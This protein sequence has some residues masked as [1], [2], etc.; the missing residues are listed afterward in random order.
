MA[1]NAP[2]AT[3]MTAGAD[4]GRRRGR[5]IRTPRGDDPDEEPE[6]T[7]HDQPTTSG[8]TPGLEPVSDRFCRWPRR[9]GSG[10]S[11]RAPT[12]MTSADGHGQRERADDPCRPT[13][14]PRAGRRAMAIAMKARKPWS[15]PQPIE[16]RIHSPR[17]S[18]DPMT[19][20]QTAPD[21]EGDRAGRRGR[22]PGRPATDGHRLGLGQL[23][24]GH[25]EAHRGIARRAELGA[26]PRRFGGLA[27]WARP[28][29]AGSPPAACRRRRR[30]RR[31][32]WRWRCR[33]V[34]QGRGSGRAAGARGS[35]AG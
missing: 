5:P 28:G 17:N 16:P 26:Q 15:T 24:M 23:D 9:S 4:D 12:P 29:V 20:R 22:R 33:R 1:V 34:V 25:G 3:P 10:S 14:R 31:A 13:S 18:A 2:S 19:T 32:R 7:D 21:D 11:A 6:Q 30:W 35:R 8:R 27:A